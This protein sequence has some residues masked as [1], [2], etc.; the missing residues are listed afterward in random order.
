M[1]KQN[2]VSLQFL[3]L[4][5]IFIAMSQIPEMEEKPVHVVFKHLSRSLLVE[6]VFAGEHLPSSPSS[7]P[8]YFPADPCIVFHLKTT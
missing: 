3:I 8:S 6:R 4:R 2:P 1:Q 7:S 5:R